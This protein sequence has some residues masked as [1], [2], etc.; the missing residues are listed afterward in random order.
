MLAPAIAPESTP[1]SQPSHAVEQPEIAYSAEGQA[2]SEPSELVQAIAVSHAKVKDDERFSHYF[3]MLAVGVPLAALKVKMNAEGVDP[4][5]IDD[6][7]A[8][9]PPE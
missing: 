1:A 2:A 6:P 3:K 8:A 4:S 7:D 9:P 5:I